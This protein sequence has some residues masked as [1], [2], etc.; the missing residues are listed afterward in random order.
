MAIGMN[1]MGMNGM[2]MGA[3]MNGQ[4]PMITGLL[5]GMGGRGVLQMVLDARRF[6]FNGDEMTFNTRFDQLSSA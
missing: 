3:Q 6:F 4:M 2:A 5:G 1:G